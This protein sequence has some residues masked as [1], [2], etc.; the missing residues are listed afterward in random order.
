MRS[1]V[2]G[3]LQVLPSVLLHACYSSPSPSAV[4]EADV[5]AALE[6]R[7][8][9]GETVKAAIEIA[10]LEPLGI[11]VPAVPPGEQLLD[12][13]ADSA[14]FWHAC[15]LAFAPSVRA[16][17]HE[18]RAT[19]L[20]QTAAGSV[21]PLG[22]EVDNVD[23]G[24][25][26]RETEV[27]LT[28][29]LLSLF[30]AGRS[31][32]ARTLAQ[33]RTRAQLASLE[34]SAWAAL[35]AVD[36]ARLDLAAARTLESRLLEL[37]ASAELDRPRIEILGERGW[38]PS[39]V[40]D[41]A[42]GSLYMIDN[43]ITQARIAISEGQRAL[44]Q[45]AGLL[46]DHPLIARVS[47]ATLERQLQQA[48]GER[49]VPAL[50]QV[51]RVHPLTR[52]RLVEYA[53]AEAELRVMVNEAVPEVRIGPQGVFSADP[54]LLGGFLEV[55]FPLPG[56]IGPRVNAA[57]ER[58]AAARSALEDEVSALYSALKHKV[59]ELAQTLIHHDQHL[60]FTHASMRRMFDA[61]RAE[62]KVD[63]RSIERWTFNLDETVRSLVEV[64]QGARAA[65]EAALDLDELRGPPAEG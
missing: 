27:T 50:E 15:A 63:Q 38:L 52:R 43:A 20:E 48:R 47:P 29:E 32:A 41:R 46:P 21:Q 42:I 54:F 2:R 16:A 6:Q 14:D 61:T 60:Q 19:R 33:A 18:F 9:N 12:M 44:A 28:V 40:L 64:V 26:D 4:S 25:P 1:A 39:S 58:R 7:A 22:L 45:S 36:R 23:F 65:A 10:A 37:K 13:D 55:S 49:V 5:A 62:F 59:E 31:G 56:T 57:V 35:F 3:L 11:P 8:R 34:S 30:S 51:A 53:L 17:R 24:G